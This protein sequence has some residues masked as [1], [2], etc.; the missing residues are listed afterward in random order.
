MKLPDGNKIRLQVA[1]G[2]EV[3][4]YRSEVGISRQ[5]LADAIGVSDSTLSKI[6]DGQ[7]APSVFVLQKI[8]HELDASLD[9]LVPVLINEARVA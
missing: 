4:R 9:D 8:A 3:Q 6:E 5:R 1:I 7:Q 2:A